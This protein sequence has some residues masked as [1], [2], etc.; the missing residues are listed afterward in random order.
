VVARGGLA[1]GPRSPLDRGREAE[2]PTRACDFKDAWGGS[3][4]P[5]TP[6]GRLGRRGFL[7]GDLVGL[8]AHPPCAKQARKPA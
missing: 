3:P 8:L 4:K 5:G 1:Q 7:V 6:S 2:P